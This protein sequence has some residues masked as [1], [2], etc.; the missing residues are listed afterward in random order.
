M[1]PNIPSA[2]IAEFRFHYNNRFNADIFAT[3]IEGC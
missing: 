2:A 3:A 1:K